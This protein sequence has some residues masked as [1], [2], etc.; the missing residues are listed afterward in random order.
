MK[1]HPSICCVVS[2]FLLTLPIPIPDKEKKIKLNFYFY[3]SLSCLKRVYE[4]LHKTFGAT[5]KKCKNKN[6]T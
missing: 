2:G 3:T 1:K 4:G 5:T 6:L